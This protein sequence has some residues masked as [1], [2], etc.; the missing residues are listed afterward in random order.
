MKI[1]IVCEKND[2]T[3]SEE[4]KKAYP[5]GMGNCLAAFL[6]KAGHDAVVID[7]GKNGVPDLKDELLESTDVL[8]WWGH[9]YHLAVADET[10][11]KIAQRVLRGMGMVFLHSAHDSKVF[12]RLLGTA[13]SLTWREDGELERLWCVDPAHP[14]ARGLGEF[15]DIPQEEMYGEPFDIPTPDEL[16]YVGWFEGGEVFRGGC[17]FNRGRGR[18]FY[19]NPGHE[20]YPTYHIPA[21]QQLLVQAAEY[22]APRGG[23]AESIGCKHRDAFSVPVR[24]EGK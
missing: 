14:I 11:E 5:E 16:V 20:T 8:F 17:V 6:R 24:K 7:A 4:G 1:T 23:F 3:E 9:V 2:G 12:K 19:F 15:I 13:C 21:V 22:V 10:V 18:I